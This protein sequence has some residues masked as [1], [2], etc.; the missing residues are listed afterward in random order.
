MTATV[1][2]STRCILGEGPLWHPRTQHFYWFDIL[3]KRLYRHDGQAESHWQFD[4][5]VSAAGWLSETELLVASQKRLFRFDTETGAQEDVAALEVDNPVTRSN[6]GRADPQ[7]GFW[8]GTMGIGLEP[9]EGA[10]YRYYRGELR[11]LYAPITI[12][13]AICFAPDGDLAYFADTPE[14]KIWSVRLDA[15]GWPKGDPHVFVD[16]GAEQLNPDG[17]VVDAGGVLWNAQWGASRVAG[18][19]EHGKFLEA[20]D[21]GARQASCPAFG[22]SDLST[23]FVTTAS[24][25]VEDSDPKSGM[26]FAVETGLVG[27]R[28]HRVVL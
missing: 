19:T 6:D 11:R 26:V 7:G 12:P 10:I 14:R 25:G 22:G 24:E 23:L 8:I 16:L 27:Q 18:Y 21:V 1:F 9:K 2:S 20:F 17:A 28:E 15:D 3:A 4:E 5:Y 13:N